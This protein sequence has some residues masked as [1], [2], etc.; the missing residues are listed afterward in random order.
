MKIKWGITETEKE[1]CEWLKTA[2]INQGYVPVIECV[3]QEDDLSGLKYV[4][5][6]TIDVVIVDNYAYYIDKYVIH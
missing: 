4:S 3:L 6:K 2:S 1:K 5:N